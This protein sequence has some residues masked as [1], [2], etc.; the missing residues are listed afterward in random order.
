MN[1][2]N[3]KEID[4]KDGKKRIQITECHAFGSQFKNLTHGSIHELCEPA[5]GYKQG[6][7]GY[8]VMGVGEPVLVLYGE[9]KEI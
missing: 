8:W 4:L 5:E 9:F 7:R 6:E 1:F 3:Q 2:S